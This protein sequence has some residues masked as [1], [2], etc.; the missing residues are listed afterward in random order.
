MEHVIKCRYCHNDLSHTFV[1]LGMSP[2]SNAYVTEGAGMERFFPLHA[3]VCDTCLLVQL[4]VFETPQD[5]F[6]DYA[7]FSSYSDSWLSHAKQY[8]DKITKRLNLGSDS[9]V[10]EIA[11]NDGYLLQ[12]FIE[13]GINVFGIEPA[14][15]VAEVARSKGINTVSEFF[16]SDLAKQLED[17]KA[18]LIVANNVLAH[19]PDINDFVRGI[20]LL[21]KEN[22]IATLEFP[23]VL[24]LIRYNQFDTIYHEHFSYL[25]LSVACKVFKS[26]DLD[27]FDVDELSTHGGS[28]RIYVCH[29][30][31][32][33][34]STNVVSALSYEASFGLNN[35]ETYLSFSQKT[36][37]A[38]R[39]ILETLIAIKDE[40]KTIVGYGAAAKGNTLLNYCGIRDD[41]L[42]YVVDKNPHKQKQ[43]L[44]GTRLAV[45]SPDVIHKTKPDYIFIIPWNLK[46]EII[47]QLDY[48]REWGGKFI[49]PIPEIEAI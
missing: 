6:S 41:F 7:Y 23:S 17:R 1:D 37:Q 11:S 33:D 21:L 35:L 8:V 27:I 40:G 46:Y 49:I 2:L 30:G 10:V 26:A 22:S 25:S 48:V 44:P 34:I 28:L 24:N 15:N 43:L 20:K 42:E 16:G 12:Y 36:R 19:V 32:R 13:R 38:K 29:S 39:R 9:L 47:N 18:D 45:H 31:R 4:P 14:K 3:Y 5:I